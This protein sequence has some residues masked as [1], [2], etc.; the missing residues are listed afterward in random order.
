MGS[1]LKTR[2]EVQKKKQKAFRKK[3]KDLKVN[4]DLKGI[5]I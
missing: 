2:S 1:R 3:T 4:S 5:Y